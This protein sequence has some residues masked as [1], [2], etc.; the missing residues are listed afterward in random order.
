MDFNHD[1]SL[2]ITVYEDNQNCIRLLKD[3]KSSSRT[4][5][6]DIKYNFVRDLY[7]S[8]YIDVKYCSS[9]RMIADLLTK[10]LGREKIRQLTND[11]GLLW[12]WVCN[13]V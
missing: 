9:A 4:K 2:P 10:P 11:I 12:L 8:K 3:Q 1:I 7:R 5:H 13:D 6:I